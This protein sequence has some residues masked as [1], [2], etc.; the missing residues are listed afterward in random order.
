M[1]GQIARHRRE[2]LLDLLEDRSRCEERQVQV[3]FGPTLDNARDEHE[4]RFDM[5]CSE[6][7]Y[8]AW[9]K[10]DIHVLQA[11]HTWKTTCFGGLIPIRWLLS[12]SS[13]GPLSMAQVQVLGGPNPCEALSTVAGDWSS[14]SV[15]RAYSK[16]STSWPSS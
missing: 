16:G 4:Q 3:R 5:A 12:K 7:R 14:T 6:D 2:L 1:V 13:L 8:R 9:E 10:P 15:A 11:L